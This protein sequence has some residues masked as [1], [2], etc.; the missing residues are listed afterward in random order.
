[1]ANEN[2]GAHAIVSAG[3]YEEEIKLMAK[4]TG[5]YNNGSGSISET[6]ASENGKEAVQGENGSTISST[7][8]SEGW[9]A[10]AIIDWP[11]K[12]FFT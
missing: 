12:A 8:F 11:G 3:C 1:M 2:N 7:P 4:E 5:T 10:D 6:L 9:Y